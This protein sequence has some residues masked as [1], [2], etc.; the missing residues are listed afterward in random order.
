[1]DLKQK[2]GDWLNIQSL[3]AKT[4]ERR[5]PAEKLADWMSDK[6]GSMTFLA[7]NAIW[8]AVWLAWNTGV[9]PGVEPFDPFP[10]GLLTTIVSLEAIFLAVF[11]L[12][13]QNR[14]ARVAELREEIDL[15]INIRTETE[16]TKLMM[17][18]YML[19]EKQG[20]DLSED[21]DLQLMLKPVD[22]DEIEQ[23]LEQE[24]VRK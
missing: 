21:E 11:V 6:F 8:F 14:A 24:I 23:A 9:I 12:I 5:T 7:F 16:L 10:F 13:S 18:V 3:R 4:D 22:M 20:I 19:A 1:M 15:Q 17:M 2:A